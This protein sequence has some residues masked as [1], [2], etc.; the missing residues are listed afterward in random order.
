MHNPRMWVERYLRPIFRMFAFAFATAVTL[1]DISCATKNGLRSGFPARVTSTPSGKMSVR[2]APKMKLCAEDNGN[3]RSKLE[4]CFKKPAVHPPWEMKLV[5]PLHDNEIQDI[6]DRADEMDKNRR[7]NRASRHMRKHSWS[8]MREDKHL[9]KK[10]E[11][12]E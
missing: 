7:V 5:P 12:D 3:S 9:K 2:D 1:V 6:L 11:K 10:W 4:S 8:E